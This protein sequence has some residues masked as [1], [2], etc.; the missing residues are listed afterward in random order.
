[1]K[2]I[3]SLD[4]LRALA[5]LAVI[6][7]HFHELLPFG[8]IGVQ[9]FFVLSGYLIT[10]ILLRTR[11]LGK[12]DYFATFFR[13][14]SLRLIPLYVFYICLLA[15]FYWLLRKPD[16]FPDALPWLLSYS[17]N[18]SA[19]FWLVRGY[20][21]GHLWTLSVEWQYYLLFPIATYFLSEKNI[22]RL[23]AAMLLAAPLVRFLHLYIASSLLDIGPSAACD[24]IH[25]STWTHIDA[26]SA[27][28]LIAF[29]R[30]RAFLE[31]PATLY[32]SL[33][34]L[35]ASGSLVLSMTPGASLVSLGWAARMDEHYQI[36][37][38]FS[39]LN[40]A[41]AAMVANVL[42]RHETA[43]GLLRNPVLVYLGTISYGIYVYHLIGIILIN[44][45]WSE[46]NW[47]SESIGLIFCCVSAILLAAV[48]HRHLESFFLLKKRR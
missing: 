47:L 12:R 16:N 3:P 6:A 28:G 26:F 21:F 38:G 22:F 18:F 36:V 37:W 19:A 14:R 11:H 20:Y 25:F 48:S 10:Q 31:R 40:I 46:W 24:Q 8:W 30:A 1:M 43:F 29:P 4:S 42:N 45:L 39:L 33:L 23:L 7:F 5:A 44:G 35:A 27:G 15:G 34:A 9:F 13:N 41:S 32:A 2:N 17:Y